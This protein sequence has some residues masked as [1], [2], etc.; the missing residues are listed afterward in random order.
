MEVKRPA[1]GNTTATAA[2]GK[3]AAKPAAVQRKPSAADILGRPVAGDVRAL[4]GGTSVVLDDPASGWLVE[5]GS[6]DVFAVLTDEEAAASSREFL[7]SVQTGGI[8]FGLDTGNGDTGV[9]LIAVG[10]EDSRVSRF[11]FSAPKDTP[12]AAEQARAVAL[13]VNQWIF[14]LSQGITKHIAERATPQQL[15]SAGEEVAVGE[16]ERIT[17]R[18]GVVWSYLLDGAVRLIDIDE[19]DAGSASVLVPVTPKSWLQ[20]RG[21]VKVKGYSTISM[22]QGAGWRLRLHQFHAMV[23]RCLVFDFRNAAATEVKR[24]RLLADKVEADKNQTLGRFASLLDEKRAGRADFEGEDPLFQASSMVADALGITLA[25]PVQHEKRREDEPPISIEEIARLSRIRTRQVALRGRWWTGDNGPLVAFI[26][27]GSRPIALLPIKGKRYQAYDPESDTM[28]PVTTRVALTLSPI[29]YSCN[30]PLPDRKLTAVDLVK[31]GLGRCKADLAA[32]LATGALGGLL[33]IAT[34]LATA[35]VFDAI[36]PGHE[37]GQLYQIGLGLLIAAFATLAFKITGDIA[38]LRIEGK[39]AGSLQAAVLDRLLRLPNTFFNNYAAGDL[40]TRT[41]MVESIRRAVTGI[42]ISSLMSGVFSIFSFALLFYYV[43]AAALVAAALFVLV[44]SATVLAGFKRLQAIMQGEALSG[45]IYSLVLQIVTG[46]TKLR[47]AGAEDRAFNL[48]GRTFGELRARMVRSKKVINLYAV[49]TAGYEILAMAAIFGVVALI[50]DEDMTTGVFLAFVAAFTTFLSSITQMAGS[51]IQV[52]ATVPMYRRAVP[53]LEALPEVDES[54]EDPGRITGAIEVNRITFRYSR[55]A[56]RILDGITMHI[57]AGEFVAII[58]PSGCGKSTLMKL[59]LGFEK[60]EGGGIYYDGQEVRSI[61][62]QALRRQI[63]V[64]LQNGRLMPGSIYENIKGA[65]DA[66]V[67]QAWEAA[68]QSGLKQDIEQMPMGMHTVLTEGASALSG[69][70]V[71]R[72]L[73]ARA[74]V[75]KPRVLLFDEAT[76]ALDNRTQAVVTQSLERLSVTRI[77]IA[78]RL[79]T[80]ASAD[81]IYVLSGGKVAESGTYDELMEKNGIFADLARRQLT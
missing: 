28:T 46:I 37:K 13:P 31:F 68:A 71:Q 35:L 8:L 73:I 81:C 7:F 75:G 11:E 44:M 16:G 33:G 77:A 62:L 40:A 14:G 43:P 19:L 53:I 42:V 47:L 45:S 15:I 9:Q 70:Q 55:E 3:P 10:W 12:L 20:G 22:L 59:L 17:S 63:G 24:L 54:K 50:Q 21:D 67:D 23:L 26:E 4:G 76:S 30:P 58:G 65:T 29:A 57:K 52:F 41:M 56:P 39:L 69:G 66:T 72:L 79:S 38:T 25:P 48:W 64:V 51:I 74:L 80:V 6:V 49:F 5:A 60:P 1:P 78:H 32:I 34:P 27:D 2:P 61:D 36:I 18:R